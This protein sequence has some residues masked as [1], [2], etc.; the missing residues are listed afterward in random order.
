MGKYQLSFP[1][2][3]SG[4]SRAVVTNA[5]QAKATSPPR[6]SRA[7]GDKGKLWGHLLK[8]A[9]AKLASRSPTSRPTILFWA[10]PCYC[11]SKLYKTQQFLLSL[12]KIT[13]QTFLKCVMEKSDSIGYGCLGYG[14]WEESMEKVPL[15]TEQG[16]YRLRTVPK[17]ERKTSTEGKLWL[18]EKLLR[19][20]KVLRKM[21][22][23]FR[24]TSS[25]QRER[26]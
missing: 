10:L 13:H 16:G 3:F 15:I 24:N 14:W 12:F 9:E 5:Q 4:G 25:F 17:P 1:L 2:N 22:L 23:C 20:T 8:V 26:P 19:L 11:L 6:H 21:E 18:M 7:E